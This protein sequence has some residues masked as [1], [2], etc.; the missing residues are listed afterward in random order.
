MNILIDEFYKSGGVKFIGIGTSLEY[1][2]AYPSPFYENKSLVSGNNWKYGQAKLNIFKH[3]FIIFSSLM[4]IINLIIFYLMI[5][6][7]VKD[8]N[9][10]IMNIISLII[11]ICVIIASI[12]GYD[13]AMYEIENKVINIK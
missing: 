9:L 6:N 8:N 13:D 2:W 12:L 10:L 1:D 3:L 5:K 11:N 7:N 4:I